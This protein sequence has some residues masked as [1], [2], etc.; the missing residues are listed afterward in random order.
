MKG[1]QFLLQSL[2][3]QITPE[4]V[5]EAWDK[6]KDAVP[7]IA[8]EIE[9]LNA[10]MARMEEKLDLLLSRGQEV[11]PDPMHQGELEQVDA[12]SLQKA[13]VNGSPDLVTR[14]A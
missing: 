8:R 13:F 12:N 10:R 4:Q 1:L 3:L 11:T 6:S 5:K 2:G 9:A 14:N 7:Q